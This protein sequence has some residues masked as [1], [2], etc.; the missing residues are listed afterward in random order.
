MMVIPKRATTRDCP[1]GYRKNG[2]VG[3]MVG[4]F[5]PIVNTL[6]VTNNHIFGED[7]HKGG[8]L[9]VDKTKVH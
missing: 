8:L 9:P 2:I 5:P 6:L 3:D 1:Y 7:L 4:T